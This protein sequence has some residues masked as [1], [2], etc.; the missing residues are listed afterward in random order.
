MS[1]R[2]VFLDL[3]T[4]GLDTERCE[5]LE[6]GLVIVD[7]DLLNE[8]AYASWIRW[9]GFDAY[10]EMGAL[11]MH[12]K[13]GFIEELQ[14]ANYIGR[15]STFDQIISE[16]MQFIRTYEAVGSPMC[17][18]TVGSYDRSIV[19]RN[20][21]LVDK[22]FGYR[23]IDVSSVKELAKA[24]HPHVYESRPKVEAAHRAVP[25]CRASIEELQHY[26]RAIFAFTPSPAPPEPPVFEMPVGYDDSLGR[27]P[28]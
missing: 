9:P 26:R 1:K 25:D 7:A 8:I 2:W 27:S 15:T 24:W 28:T 4:T 14:K 22:L 18:S 13:S 5:V 12:R 21:P 23:C 6:L 11:E 17:G 16:A 3:E 20:F 19:R 10:W